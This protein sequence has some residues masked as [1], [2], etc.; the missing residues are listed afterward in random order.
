MAWLVTRKFDGAPIGCVDAC[1]DAEMIALNFGYYFFV[2][3]W[4]KGYATEGARACL[5]YAWNEL[6]QDRIVAFTVPT[7]ARSRNVME[8]IGMQHDAANDFDHPMLPDWPEKRHVLYRIG[9]AA[10]EAGVAR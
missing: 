8:K 3:S 10:W 6:N 5:E 2:N 7:N 9:R 1:I 4:G